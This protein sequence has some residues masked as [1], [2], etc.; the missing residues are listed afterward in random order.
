MPKFQDTLVK[1]SSRLLAKLRE[2]PPAASVSHP[3]VSTAQVAIRALPALGLL[4]L[5]PCCH[6]W[7]MEGM[8]V[9]ILIPTYCLA[10]G[11]WLVCSHLTHGILGLVRLPMTS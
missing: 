2:L 3:L 5:F 6:L 11:P 8:F 10:S 1:W 9:L 7:L 4:V